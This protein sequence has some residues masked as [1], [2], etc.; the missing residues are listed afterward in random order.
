MS[1]S[2]YKNQNNLTGL[3]MELSADEVS[4]LL[5]NGWATLRPLTL[6][7]GRLP[8]SSAQAAA[9]AAAAAAAEA[10]SDAAGA[11]VPTGGQGGG[12]GAG[13]AAADAARSSSAAPS[14]SGPSNGHLPS[15]AG[16][17]GG[18]RGAQANRGGAPSDGLAADYY[19][20]YEG[21]GA[22][23]PPGASGSGSSVVAGGVERCLALP[24]WPVVAA[25]VR[26]HC[27]CL[28]LSVTVCYFTS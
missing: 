12:G 8:P 9:A 25:Q 10:E 28:L 26:T 23:G 14:T 16:N 22:Y 2:E 5:R 3:P 19:A 6:H 21:L 11:G 18:A 4:L 15:S 27:Y 13:S 20:Y 24:A 1:I 17:G 7:A